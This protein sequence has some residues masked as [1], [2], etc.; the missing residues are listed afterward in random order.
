MNGSE[1]FLIL[2]LVMPREMPDKVYRTHIDSIE[3]CT[4]Q[5]KAFTDNGITEAMQKLGVIAVMGAC[6]TDKKKDE[7]KT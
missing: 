2:T 3:E 6:L 7:G 4:S 1:V 5:V